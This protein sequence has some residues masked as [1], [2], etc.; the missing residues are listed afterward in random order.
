MSVAGIVTTGLSQLASVQR[1][2]QQVRGEFKQLGQDLQAGNLTQAQTDFV[3][4]S[5]SMATQLSS[6]S[7]VSKALA[8]LGQALQSG[9]LSAAQQAFANMPPGIVGPNA[10]H[11]SGHHGGNASF[12][13]ALNQLGQALQSGNLSAA[14]QAFSAMQQM[15]QQMGST[16]G[17]LS[18]GTSTGSTTPPLS[19]GSL[20]VTA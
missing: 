4:L 2:Y 5:Q 9:N 14:Q 7:P 18:T 3:T 10:V 11:H 6:N 1:N 12:S 13:D 19:S 8:S 20:S 17:T 15:W 16:G